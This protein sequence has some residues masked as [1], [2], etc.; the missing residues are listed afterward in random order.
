MT[1]RLEQVHSERK[2]LDC[3]TPL[4][5]EEPQ[6][7]C[8]RCIFQRLSRTGSTIHPPESA[9]GLA[10]TEPAGR[11]FHAEYELLGEIGR[12]GMGVIYKAHQPRLNRVVAIKVIHA[13]Q[14]AGEA[15]RRRFEA[16]MQTAAR[17]SH[18]NIVPVFDTGVMDGCPCF[19]MEYFPGG[20]LAACMAEFAVNPAGGVRLLVKVARAVSFAH[21]RGVLHRDLKP[22][23]IL[24]DEAGE[25]HVADFGLAKQLDS[26][27]D[28]TRAGAVLGS[29]SYMSPEQA[30]GRSES[31]TVAT[32][33][34]SLGVMLYE[35]LAGRTPF[36]A[37]T[38]LETMRLVVERE[39]QRPSTIVAKV[40]RDLETICLKCLRKEPE[41]R[42]RTAE[43]LADDLDRWL[44]H[45]PIQARPVPGWERFE[46]WVRRHPALALMNALLFIALASGVGGVL[47]QWR[48]AEQARSGEAFERRRAEEALARSSIAL[49]ESAVR[50][51]NTPAARAAL[52]AVPAEWR[53]ATWHY[54]LG[55]SDTSRSLASIGLQKVDDIA[56][57][58][59]RPSVFAAAQWS[60]QIV[61]FDVRT[62]SRLLEFTPAFTNGVTNM[63]LRLAFSRD[64]R[65]MVVGRSRGTGLVIHDVRDGRKLSEWDAPESDRLEFS[66]DATMILQTTAARISTVLW[67]AADGT[68]R[69]KHKDGLSS[70][71]FASDPH[72]VVHYSWGRQLHLAAV[73]D[74]AIETR[75]ATS[76]FF[77]NFALQPGGDVLA[78][79]NPLGFVR[80]YSLTNGQQRFEFQPHE[81]AIAYIAFLPGGERFLTAA[82]LQDGR[83]ALQSWESRNGRA[84]Q[85]LTGGYGDIRAIALHPLSGELIVCGREVR[86][87]DVATLPPMRTIH[88]RNEHPSAVFWADDETIFAPNDGGGS[89]AHVW[90]Q[91]SGAR[92][93][94]WQSPDTGLGQPSV[95]ANGRRAAIGRYNSSSAVYVLER[96]GGTVQRIASLNPRC[97]ISHLRI[98][99]NGDRVAIVQSD[100]GGLFIV[101]VDTNKR[102]VRPEV[103]DVTGFTDVA[104]LEGGASLA[105]LVTTHAPRSTPGAV[106]QIVLWDMATGRRV[107]SVTNATVTRVACPA[108]DGRRFAEAG[109]DRNVRI[110]DGATL[111][112]V[113]EMRVHNA[114]ITALAWHPTRPILATA[115]E[116]LVI[117]L[118]DMDT[119]ARL[120]ELRGPLSPPSV[121][122]FSPGG[123]RLATAARDG[124]ARIWEP[125]S[126]ADGPGRP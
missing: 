60:G 108:P 111:G 5:A 117:R 44:R 45:E 78:V 47:W 82:K 75:L 27:S 74:G 53:N 4:P 41:Q 19:S 46:K 97:V 89:S 21:Q 84:C 83:Q 51:G 56:G 113:Q 68:Q 98:S 77:D 36:V 102:S 121:L 34:Y 66:P 28:V 29:P 58:P 1:Q 7:V 11:D 92:K 104:W 2:C 55:E 76:G 126:L 116:D 32:D 72:Q 16:E 37:D 42:Y 9:P 88:S 99:P 100:L 94:L 91:F 87:W 39:A 54:L 123:T 114:P 95:S 90:F 61:L 57:D 110:R 65:K 8:P 17:L 79:A 48:R 40:N 125:R 107:Q 67:N 18:P 23:N 14:V 124:V 49:A 62:L 35:M 112:V 106:E 12:G 70:A 71:V 3:G 50:D 73:E 105:G 59:S 15:A 101:D 10:A 86:I 25:P 93:V 64:G 85:T 119:G 26:D 31:L 24:L 120:E 22:A 69:W 103:S 81:G 13:A 63:H 43:E 115:S 20:T 6:P 122:S 109:A 96:N 52:E 30:A 80:G 118:W 33:I 38:P